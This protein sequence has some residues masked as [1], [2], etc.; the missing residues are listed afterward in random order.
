[1]Q[2]RRKTICRLSSQINVNTFTRRARV[3]SEITTN[4][5]HSYVFHVAYV[6]R[7]YFFWNIIDSFP[8]LFRQEK[9]SRV[10]TSQ[11]E[12]VRDDFLRNFC[13]SKLNY[14]PSR[15]IFVDFVNE[16][17][18]IKSFKG[19]KRLNLNDFILNFFLLIVKC[20]TYF[21]TKCIT[22]W[23]HTTYISISINLIANFYSNW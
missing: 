2:V 17:L 21:Q 23:W 16:F 14:C 11:G 1:M 10:F 19:K 13:V 22:L 12:L 4:C 20:W 7:Q 5:T 6:C 9:L 15:S 8:A 3:T 18:R